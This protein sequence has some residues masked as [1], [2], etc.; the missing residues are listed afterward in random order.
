VKHALVRLHLLRKFVAE[1]LLLSEL[2]QFNGSSFRQ[3]RLITVVKKILNGP[4]VFFC[5]FAQER[6]KILIRPYLLA[7]RMS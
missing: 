6:F 7:S 5:P 1:S 3:V 2:D 4:D